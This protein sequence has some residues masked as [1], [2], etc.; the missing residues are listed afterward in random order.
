[1]DGAA[2]GAVSCWISHSS[3]V[4]GDHHSCA[5]CSLGAWLTT[6]ICR[7]MRHL[8]LSCLWNLDVGAGC[9]LSDENPFFFCWKMLT[10][11]SWDF[12]RVCFSIEVRVVWFLVQS[13]WR[14]KREKRKEKGESSALWHNQS[15]WETTKRGAWA[16]LWVCLSKASQ[17]NVTV[18]WANSY[19]GVVDVG[20]GQEKRIFLHFPPFLCPFTKHFKRICFISVW[21]WKKVSVLFMK[22]MSSLCLALLWAALG[23]GIFLWTSADG[24]HSAPFPCLYNNQLAVLEMLVKAA[25]HTCLL[26]GQK[27]CKKKELPHMVQLVAS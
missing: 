10:R 9:E 22:G 13:C 19:Q 7:N 14:G 16:L 3:R 18:S 8:K 12:H 23:S 17:I 5:P 1:M 24:T 26:L 6:L 2:T 21:E 20:K 25:P 11:H 27:C 4:R 15:T